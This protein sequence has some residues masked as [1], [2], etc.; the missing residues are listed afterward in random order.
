ML[1]KLLLSGGIFSEG[2]KFAVMDRSLLYIRSMP[3]GSNWEYMEVRNYIR[4]SSTTE[5]IRHYLGSPYI[6]FH[7]VS[8]HI[9]YRFSVYFAYPDSIHLVIYFVYL[10]QILVLIHVVATLALWATSKTMPTPLQNG[11]WTCSSWTAATPP[12]KSTR[13]GIPT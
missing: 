5:R 7:V 2:C 13:R 10:V 4:F 3:R 12:R 9:L 11:A 6:L 8:L 1:V